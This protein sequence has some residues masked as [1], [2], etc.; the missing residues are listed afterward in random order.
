MQDETNQPQ[1]ANEP[2]DGRRPWITPLV[3]LSESA[4]Q[5]SKIPPDPGDSS[6]YGLVFGTS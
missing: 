6:V 5:T 3:V 1:S 4:G 2:A